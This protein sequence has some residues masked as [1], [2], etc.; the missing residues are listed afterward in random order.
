MITQS[1]SKL[2][3]TITING[4][5][6]S[7]STKPIEGSSLTFSRSGY[8]YNIDT[9]SYAAQMVAL[10]GEVDLGENFANSDT[11]ALWNITFTTG[12]VVGDKVFLNV[13]QT[14]QVNSCDAQCTGCECSITSPTTST[15]F[16]HL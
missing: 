11:T 7:A 10:T 16:T 3:G 1:N 4:L 14:I 2:S 9:F 8:N 5:I 13:P 15:P 12:V 6:A